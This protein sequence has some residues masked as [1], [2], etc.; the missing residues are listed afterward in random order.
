MVRNLMTMSLTAN[1]DHAHPSLPHSVYLDWVCLC[2]GMHKRSS[3]PVPVY[4]AVPL[5]LP[6]ERVQLL[7]QARGREGMEVEGHVL[8]PRCKLFNSKKISSALFLFN[9]LRSVCFCPTVKSTKEI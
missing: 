3:L 8:T 2:S 1:L 6:L 5:L 7:Q 4:E 9:I